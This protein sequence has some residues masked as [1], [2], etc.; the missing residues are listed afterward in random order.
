MQVS[1]TDLQ[2]FLEGHPYLIMVGVVLDTLQQIE[3][4]QLNQTHGFINGWNSCQRKTW[5][6]RIFWILNMAKQASIEQDGIIE[7]V[8][9][10]RYFPC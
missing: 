1:M 4:Y 9:T 3:T 7:E 5:V 10:K 2:C 8:I 6:K